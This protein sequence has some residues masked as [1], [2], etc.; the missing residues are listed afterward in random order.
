MAVFLSLYQDNRKDSKFKGKW[1]ARA[2][3]IGTK[4]LMDIA[5]MIQR[6]SSM[7]RSDVAAVLLEAS[8]VVGDFLAD[9]YRVKLNGL[10]TLKVGVSTLPADTEKEFDLAKNVKGSHIL[11]QPETEKDGSHKTRSRVIAK[12]LEFKK[13][14]VLTEKKAKKP[15][16][17]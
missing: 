5:E 13:V 14:T 12:K 3:T 6:N 10:G 9:G 4:D 17:P 16:K 2:K 1:Y 8:E 11:F 15:K 7:K